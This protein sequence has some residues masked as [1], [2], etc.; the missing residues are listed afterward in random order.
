M[1]MDVVSKSAVQSFSDD[2]F[3]IKSNIVVKEFLLFQLHCNLNLN[4]HVNIRIFILHCE[5]TILIFHVTF[6]RVQ[7]YQIWGYGLFIS[8]QFVFD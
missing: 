4:E 1:E 7:V 5:Q 2:T 6:F 8:Q 3:V